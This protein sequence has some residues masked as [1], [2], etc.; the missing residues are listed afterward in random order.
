[1]PFDTSVLK[2]GFA[3][4]ILG[5]DGSDIS[6]EDVATLKSLSQTYPVMILRDQ[7]LNEDQQAA[8]GEKFGPLDTN[9]GRSDY[10]RGLRIDLLGVSNVGE[11][12]ELLAADDRRRALDMGN[13]F[14]HTDSSF[15]DI[16]AHLSMLYGVRVAKIGGETQ[17]ADLRAGYETLS[18]EMKRL[19][20]QLVAL[21]SATHSRR[22]MGFD[23]FTEGL[24]DELENFVAHEVVRV[25]PETGRKTLYLSAH[26]SQIVGLSVP[27][28]RVLL[29]ELIEHATSPGNVFTHNWRA[30]DLV[31]WDNR[32]TMHRLRRY[33]ATQEARVLRRVTTLDPAFPAR[34]LAKVIVPDWLA[35]EA[36]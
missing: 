10:A 28:G 4:E 16:P 21:H 6:G 15:K 27:V 11:G 14:W 30:N 7:H 34:D 9:Y 31:I 8:F 5:V 24:R 18:D 25:L 22:M 26:A 29:H 2:E 32:C 1:M 19:A 23:E 12:Q 36:A 35:A 20:E 13:K 33:R 3:I 17:F